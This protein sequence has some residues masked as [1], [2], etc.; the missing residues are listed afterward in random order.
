MKKRLCFVFIFLFLFFKL[1]AQNIK[2]YD[3]NGYRGYAQAIYIGTTK[4]IDPREYA[5]QQELVYLTDGRFNFIRH[6][7]KLSKQESFLTW[8]ALYEYDL[9]DNEI[10]NLIIQQGELCLTFVA[11]IKNYGEDFDWYEG[12]VWSLALY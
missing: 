2:Y 6:C 3:Y 7:N 10:Y 11:V 5:N 9:H 8:C 1:T 4:T 12:A